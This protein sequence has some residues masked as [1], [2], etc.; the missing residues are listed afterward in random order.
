[1][2]ASLPIPGE[3][4]TRT[5]KT[6]HVLTLTPFFPAR[7]DDAQGCFVAEPLPWMEPMGVVNTVFAGRP[8]YRGLMRANKEK[9]SARWIR[10]FAVPGNAGL[11]IS[12]N[13]LFARIV[14]AVRRL[15][16]ANPVHLI[17]AHSAL[18]CGHA[19]ALLSRELNIPFIVTVHGLDAFS[20]TQV[21][22]PAG[23]WCAR[24]SQLVYRSAQRVVCVSEKVRERVQESA[25]AQVHTQV[26]YNGVDARLFAPRE[27][28]GA[29]DI[30]L[31]V[32]NLIPTKGHELL[33]RAFAAIAQRFPVLT[34][35]IIGDGPERGRLGR[36]ARELN[37]ATRVCFLGRQ[38]RRQV[39]EAMQRCT[40]F[41]LPS[42]YEGLGCVYLEA[43]AA[44][45]PAIACSGQGI[46]DIIQH[47]VNGWLIEPGDLPG[48]ADALSQ[49]LENP[50]LAQK[51][52]RAARHTVLQNFTVAEQAARLAQLYLECAA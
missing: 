47:R 4:V 37:I 27:E 26:V 15:H 19:A 1:M 45:R 36:L 40:V 7:E 22:G 43:M 2:I 41:A 20:T 9:G 11:P 14:S 24:I 13:F 29:S 8:F 17:H 21:Q 3:I 35:Q 30:I 50:Q 16:G 23:R 31:S 38:N 6:I 5:E 44:G 42:R 34:C 52:G 39:A 48:L 25:A 33:L 46:G 51:I 32:G 12:G 18:P 28:S 49:L 10:H